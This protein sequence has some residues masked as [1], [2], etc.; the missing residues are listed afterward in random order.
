MQRLCIMN[1]YRY[2][3]VFMCFIVCGYLSL[4]GM[5]LEENSIKECEPTIFDILSSIN[6][7][8]QVPSLKS[9]ALKEVSRTHHSSLLNELDQI[10]TP[11]LQKTYK[12][13]IFTQ[14][15]Q[16]KKDEVIDKLYEKKY[17]SDHWKKVP[18]LTFKNG[19]TGSKHNLAVYT[20]IEEW[21]TN[22]PAAQ[23]SAQLSGI[24]PLDTSKLSFGCLQEDP[25]SVDYKSNQ[26]LELGLYNGFV[27]RDLYRTVQTTAHGRMELPL[28]AALSDSL[29]HV[30]FQ[31]PVRTISQVDVDI[32]KEAGA[33]TLRFQQLSPN[34]Y[35]TPSLRELDNV[36]LYC[37]TLPSSL[38]DLVK[39]IVIESESTYIKNHT[40]KYKEAKDYDCFYT[41]DPYWR[42]KSV[43]QIGCGLLVGFFTVWALL[44]SVQEYSTL[45]NAAEVSVFDANIRPSLTPD[46]TNT[47]QVVQKIQPLP[48]MLAQEVGPLN[49]AVSVSS[50]S[51]ECARQ[52][53]EQA[54]QIEKGSYYDSSL[55]RPAVVG[56]EIFFC[57]ATWIVVTLKGTA[58]KYLLSM[59]S[60]VRSISRVVFSPVLA[61]DSIRTLYNTSPCKPEEF[62]KWVTPK[63]QIIV[64]KQDESKQ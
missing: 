43:A 13:C 30:Y 20:A 18:K 7:E 38:A 49:N 59:N 26:G 39:G 56:G 8:G 33:A 53:I 57:L 28:I 9:I 12:D 48:T 64:P 45:R 55:L 35:I 51:L 42:V 54:K 44:N 5:D 63:L 62:N 36:T 37:D 2:I 60:F 15:P 32:L 16:E 14:L 21:S 31:C 52:I 17:R 40:R 19:Q 3:H 29:D 11:L 46:V 47:L 50:D 1:Y 61:I 27:G 25:H 22:D 23:L 34:A 24:E 10:N 4:Y 41:Y 6:D 58:S